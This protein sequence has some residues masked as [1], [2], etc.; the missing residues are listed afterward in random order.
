MLSNH[1]HRNHFFF[2]FDRHFV[3]VWSSVSR[4]HVYKSRWSFL[5][6][7]NFLRH[8]NIPWWK[9]DCNVVN[10]DALRTTWNKCDWAYL[11]KSHHRCLTSSLIHYWFTKFVQVNLFRKS[12]SNENLENL[13]EKHYGAHFWKYCRLK[14]IFKLHQ[15]INESTMRFT[16]HSCVN[17]LLS[18]FLRKH[19]CQKMFPKNMIYIRKIRN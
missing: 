19:K 11:E 1:F 5:S 17:V 15:R 10:R 2:S 18:K 3:V 14:I 4:I 9:V 12:S 13:S 6:F 8:G 16:V 7:T